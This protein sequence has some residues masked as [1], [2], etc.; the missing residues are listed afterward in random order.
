MPRKFES[1]G[2]NLGESARLLHLPDDST[3]YQRHS[4][5]LISTDS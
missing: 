5:I 1:F 4:L 2:R 3:V